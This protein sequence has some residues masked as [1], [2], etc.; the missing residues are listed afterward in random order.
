[1]SSV[2][3]VNAYLQDR[4]LPTVDVRSPGEFAHGHIPKAINIPLFDDIERAEVGTL[5]KQVGRPA[6]ITRGLEFVGKKASC[7][8]EALTATAIGSEFFL[9]CWRGGMRS[10]GLAWFFNE[11]GFKPHRIRGGYKAFRQAARRGLAEPRRIVILSGATGS[12]K[13]RLL[14]ALKEQGSQVIDLEHLA[15][16]RGSVFGGIG[17]PPQPTVEQFENELF[18]QWRDLDPEQPVWI[19]CESQAIGRVFIPTEVWDQ[20]KHAPAVHVEVERAQRVDFL[21]EEYGDLPTDELASAIMKIKK[22][23]GGANLQVALAALERNDLHAFT[24]L[25][26][27]YYDK[28]YSLSLRKRLRC[29]TTHFK[30]ERAGE[31]ERIDDL[32]Q[33]G[34]ELTELS[35][36]Q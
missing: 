18:F 6:A 29:H 20:M 12:G 7:L 13:T 35:V 10:G 32:G 33:I 25:A 3:D 30:L 21:I 17:R 36:S 28:A 22:R 26:L 31:T 8:L 1:M 19:E 5:Y 2:I 14:S 24:E 23:L 11:C 15:G 34:V 27:D 4:Q 16:H 9:H